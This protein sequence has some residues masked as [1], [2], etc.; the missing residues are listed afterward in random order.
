[1]RFTAKII[2]NEFFEDMIASKDINKN[3]KLFY[4]L[5]KIDEKCKSVTKA[6]FNERLAHMRVL[7]Y[8]GKLRYFCDSFHV[9]VY[10]HF[11]SIP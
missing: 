7:M 10:L 4:L 2:D 9:L 11:K 3:R 1:M 5:N 8:A 6:G